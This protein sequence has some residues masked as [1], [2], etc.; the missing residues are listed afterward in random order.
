[1][2]PPRTPTAV[3]SFQWPPEKRIALMECQWEL[4]V[5]AFTICLLPQIGV[6]PVATWPPTT[7]VL[8]KM[9]KAV[10]ELFRGNLKGGLFK[11]AKATFKYSFGCSAQK[12]NKS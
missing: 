7:F 1:M 6:H 2:L 3:F 5:E 11:N 10:M 9:K 8:S 4:E 12:S